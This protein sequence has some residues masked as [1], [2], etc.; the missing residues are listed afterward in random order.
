LVPDGTRRA[1]FRFPLTGRGK[2]RPIRIARN[3][4]VDKARN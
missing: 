4:L 2:P 1:A 3:K